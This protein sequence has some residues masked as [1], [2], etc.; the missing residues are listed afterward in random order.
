[1]P[2]KYLQL[3]LRLRRFDLDLDLSV[4]LHLPT[5]VTL[6]RLGDGDRSCGRHNTIYIQFPGNGPYR[7]DNKGGVPSRA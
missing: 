7:S 6:Q 3:R 5:Y 1:M 4:N 2:V